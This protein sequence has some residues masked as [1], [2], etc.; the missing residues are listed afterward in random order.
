MQ[1][2]QMKVEREAEVLSLL[3]LQLIGCVCNTVICKIV[4]LPPWFYCRVVQCSILME[5][6]T[7]LTK[8]ALELLA[9]KFSFNLQRPELKYKPK[10]QVVTGLQTPVW[11]FN[12]I[13]SVLQAILRNDLQTNSKVEQQMVTH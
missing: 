1:Q 13:R 4:T 5:G 7:K 6:F 10:W 8:N 11:F 12:K 3:Q 2:Y 9:S